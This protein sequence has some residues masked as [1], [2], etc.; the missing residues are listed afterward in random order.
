MV[1]TL[2][3]QNLIGKDIH[4]ASRKPK[5]KP[6]CYKCKYFIDCGCLLLSCGNSLVSARNK[7]FARRGLD[8]VCFVPK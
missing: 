6:T 3:E 5:L 2:Y 8:T 1:L 4:M 7:R